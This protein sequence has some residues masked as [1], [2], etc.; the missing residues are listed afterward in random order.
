MTGWIGAKDGWL[1]IPMLPR[2]FRLAVTE[3]ERTTPPGRDDETAVVIK[4]IWLTHSRNPYIG[5]R[6]AG[7]AMPAPREPDHASYGPDKNIVFVD[8]LRMVLYEGD[9]PVFCAGA[10]V[11][12]RTS[13]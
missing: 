4:A 12:E 2:P 11:G 13:N 5:Q 7:A 10:V 1:F 9:T 8:P 6:G 3:E